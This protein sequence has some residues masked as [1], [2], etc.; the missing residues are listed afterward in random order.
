MNIYEL[1]DVL[2]VQLVVTRVANQNGRFYAHFERCETKDGGCLCG[3]HG[4]GK[5]AI[6][7]INDYSNSIAGKTLVFNAMT[8][9]RR[10]F[11]APKMDNVVA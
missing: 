2:N 10:E 5:T 11:I 3:E 1:A 4:N 6:E 9:N 7:A 8:N